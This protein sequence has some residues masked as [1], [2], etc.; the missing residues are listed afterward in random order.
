[1]GDSARASSQYP[2]PPFS[3]V[4]WPVFLT[5][6]RTVT[7]PPAKI[8]LGGAGIVVTELTC[9]KPSDELEVT[10]TAAETPTLLVSLLSA[11]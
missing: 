3:I 10:V 2:S 11:T 1:M 9:R 5:V 6:Q 8:R 4:L 7:C